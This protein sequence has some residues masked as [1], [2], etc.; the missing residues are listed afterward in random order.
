MIQNCAE[1]TTKLIFSYINKIA[2]ELDATRILSYLADMGRDL[3]GADRCTVWVADKNHTQLWTKVAHGVNTISIPYNSGLVGHAI[4]NDE[5]MIIDDVYADPRFNKEIDQQTGYTTK[6]MLIIP[7]HN[8]EGKVIGAFQVINK[9]NNEKFSYEDMNFIRL[10][11]TF[12]AETI[13]TSLLVKEIEETQKEVIFSMGEIGERRS[14]ET[15]NHVKRVAEYSR[16]LAELYGLSEKE[17]QMLKM[18]SPMHDIGKVGIP[19]AIL[20]KPAGFTKS[21]WKIMQTHAELGYNT[22]KNSTRDILQA[23]AIVAYEHHEKYNGKGYPRGLK[24]EEIHIYGRITAIA[25][26]FD[27]L[28]SDRVYKKSWP[29]E[30]IL[31]LIKEERGEH[32]DPKLVD[33]FLENV[34]KFLEV[35]EKFKD[36]YVE[37]RSHYENSIRILGAYGTKSKGKGTTSFEIDAKTM[38]DAGN[39]LDALEEKSADVEHLYISHTHLD[40]ISDIAYILDNYFSLRKKPL[41]IYGTLGTIKNIKECFLNDIIWPDFSKIHLLHSQECSVIYHEIKLNTR[42]TINETTFIEAFDTDH[43]ES[44]CGYIVYKK[45][46]SVLI[47]SDIVNIDNV[48]QTINTNKKIKALVVECSFPS[49]MRDLAIESKHLTPE[50]MFEGLKKLKREDILIYVNHLKPSFENEI[51]EEITQKQGHLEIK[52][53]KDGNLLEF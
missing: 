53:L 14:K 39:L 35:R 45:E 28:G 24:G 29:L 33:L 36:V 26:V 30:R 51:I 25:D 8:S 17:S 32:F 10:A 49:H 4:N 21:E 9:L 19:D 11:S 22:L 41:N 13:E 5:S 47:T 12:S 44:S 15:G 23:A 42:Y 52:I 37:E 6:T 20:N 27:A 16:I 38:I 2:T 18:A 34:D 43:T 7:L 3:T 46:S 40:H 1:E 48:I 31:K 50:I